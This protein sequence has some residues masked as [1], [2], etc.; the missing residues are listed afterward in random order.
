[1]DYKKIIIINLAFL[2]ILGKLMLL[3]FNKMQR[4]INRIKIEDNNLLKL[5]FDYDF[6]DNVHENH[7]ALSLEILQNFSME[8]NEILKKYEF[9]TGDKNKLDNVKFYSLK[10]FTQYLEYFTRIN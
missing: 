1:M 10:F 6:E 3:V 8:Y 4:N 7:T 5:I 2:V 9:I